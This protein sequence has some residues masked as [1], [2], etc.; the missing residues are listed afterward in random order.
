VFRAWPVMATVAIWIS[1][2]A[3]LF[4]LPVFMQKATLDEN[5]LMPTYA[6]PSQDAAGIETGTG[7]KWDPL[8]AIQARDVLTGD[9]FETQLHT[10]G[11]NDSQVTK[12]HRIENEE[13]NGNGDCRFVTSVVR[14]GSAIERGSFVVVADISSFPSVRSLMK[15]TSAAR[16]LSKDLLVIVM[17]DGCNLGQ[18]TSHWVKQYHKPE[19]AGTIDDGNGNDRQPLLRGGNLY[20]SIVLKH[21]GKVPKGSLSISIN[22]GPGLLPNMDLVVTFRKIAEE[23]FSPISLRGMESSSPSHCQSASFDQ[24]LSTLKRLAHFYLHHFAPTSVP[25][26]S[27]GLVPFRQHAID[28]IQIHANLRTSKVD[29][30]RS[31]RLVSVL[32]LL[33]RSLGNLEEKLHHSQYLYLMASPNCYVPAIF[34][35]PFVLLLVSFA[36]IPLAKLHRTSMVT[37]SRQS[38]KQANIQTLLFGLNV[39]VAVDIVGL[40]ATTQVVLVMAHSLFTGGKV[41]VS[42]GLALFPLHIMMNS[43]LFTVK[44]KARIILS[45]A[46]AWAW[47]WAITVT[48]LTPHLTDPVLFAVTVSSLVGSTTVTLLRLMEG[49]KEGEG[50]HGKKD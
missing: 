10:G 2:I 12:A 24:Y 19:V 46:L 23:F 8:D 43:N 45:L 5:G 7:S 31:Q 3:F 30:E 16:W 17:E 28:A 1:G 41:L 50:K 15:V 25:D 13:E 29:V 47:A 18:V 38:V 14:C 4:A 27:D 37:A 48:G 20:A 40:V 34:L 22:G 32:E 49:G 26:G 42:S 33:L 35:I 6:D 21:D 39:S 9:G 44:S 11:L 36:A